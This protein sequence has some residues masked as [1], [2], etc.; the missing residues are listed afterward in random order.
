MRAG[1]PWMLALLAACASTPPS[2]TLST[3]TASATRREAQA[4]GS[5]QVAVLATAPPAAEAM[6][7]WVRARLPPGGELVSEAPL[8]VRHTVQK[9]ESLLSVARAYVSLTDVYLPE[10]YAPEIVR[11]N[12]A[13]AC[14]M[15]IGGARI[16]PGTTLEIPHLLSEPPPPPRPLPKDDAPLKG[17]FL[18]GESARAPWIPTL[19]KLVARGMNAVVLDGKAYMGEI[20]YPS[21][22][23][24]AV[25]TGATRGAP[26]ADLSRTIRFAHKYGVRVVMRIAC[27]HD[28][29]TAERAPE[30]S[31]RGNWG[32]AYPI[33]WLDPA[34]PAVHDYIERLAVEQ[35]EAGADEIQLDYVRYPVQRGLGNADFTKHMG[36]RNRQTVIRDF[37]R[38]IHKV[39]KARGVALS[40]DIFGVTSTGTQEDIDNLGQDIGM[41][42]TEAEALMPMVYP[43]HYGAG[44]YGWKEPGAHPEIVGIGTKAALERLDK[45]GVKNGA[46]IRPWIQ[47]FDWRSPGFGPKYI[48]DEV[49]AAEAAGGVGWILWNPGADYGV[50]W[51]AFPKKG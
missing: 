32:G 37:V 48:R 3:P 14:T 33:G 5:A 25:R 6:P 39:T 18:V 22:V 16:G 19:E 15:C 41:L 43:S 11:A 28:P 50:T 34:N 8:R 44:F 46:V 1:A 12:P 40:V 27:F 26:I 51:L 49:N 30:L 9:G 35:I 21:K 45:A 7:A 29:W 38:R 4:P 42:G 2:P 13:V 47:A 31:V 24:V 23:D 17:I 10:T 20:T 36:G